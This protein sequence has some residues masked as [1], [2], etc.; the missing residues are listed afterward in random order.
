MS[1]RVSL[2]EQLF[3][4]AASI[5]AFAD[6]QSDRHSF[7][8][9]AELTEIETRPFPYSNLLDATERSGFVAHDLALAEVQLA[10]NCEWIG[11]EP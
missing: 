3:A 2:A 5:A 4:L 10:S 8:E 6:A 11:G 7:A 9:H 1:P